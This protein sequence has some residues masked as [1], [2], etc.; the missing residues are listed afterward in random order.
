MAKLTK[1]HL[2]RGVLVLIGTAFGLYGLWQLPLPALP[3]GNEA[4]SISDRATLPPLTPP[5]NGADL[6]EQIA[7]RQGWAQDKASTAQTVKASKSKVL[8]ISQV[9]ETRVVLVQ[10]KGRVTTYAEGQTLPDGRTIAKISPLSVAF[11]PPDG[12]ASEPTEQS[13][14]KTEESDASKAVTDPNVLELFPIDKTKL[15]PPPPV[16]PS[17]WPKSK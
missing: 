8:G 17:A 13:D 6:A 3:K 1:A 7:K 2:A 4:Q 14:R 16:D 15:Q 5:I 11:V 10:D 12:E 9:G